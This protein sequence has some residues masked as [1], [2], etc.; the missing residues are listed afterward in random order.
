MDIAIDVEEYKLNIRAAAI[1]IHNNKVLTH[2]NVNSDH[3]A[4]LGG[5]VQIGES[6]EET[7]KREVL[8][9]L[10]KNIDI[11]GYVATFENFFEM[12]GKKYHEIMF[13]YEA[14]FTDEKNKAMQETIK[15]MEGKDYLQYEWLDINEIDKYPL[16]PKVAKEIF[17]EKVWP[18]HKINID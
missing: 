15:N 10:G 11:I 4:L 14:E 16:K 3:Y 5:R 8:E 13:V 7:V 6:S 2:R 1:I 12:K 17:K 9:E 18:V